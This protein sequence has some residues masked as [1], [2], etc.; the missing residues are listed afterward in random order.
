[1][2]EHTHTHTYQN[3]SAT[4]T[5]KVIGKIVGVTHLVFLKKLLIWRHSESRDQTKHNVK[6]H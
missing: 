2:Y 1:L 3:D 6:V 5:T 4:W